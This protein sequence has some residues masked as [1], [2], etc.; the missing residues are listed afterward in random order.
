MKYF[1]MIDGRREGPYDLDNLVEVGVRP[2]TWIWAKNM[3]DWQKAADVPEV[4]RL[5]RQYLGGAIPSRNAISAEAQPEEE[6]AKTFFTPTFDVDE[7]DTTIP[8]QNLLPFAIIA[9]L[10][11]F[12]LTGIV[13][14]YFSWKA[15]AVWKHSSSSGITEE[16]RTRIRTKAHDLSR[17]AK[18]WIGMTFSLGFIMIGFM[19]FR[20]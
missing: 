5:F 4:C 11:C 12:P 18:M 17:L 6:T 14:I 9:M 2:S 16:E 13:A 10:F 20:Y 1:V 3:P 19:L 7:V 15:N 8:P